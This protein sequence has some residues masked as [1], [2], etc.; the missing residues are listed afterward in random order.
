[1]VQIIQNLISNAVKF[2][3]PPVQPQVHI[4]A[5]ENPFGIRLWV[6]DN[7]LG[8]AAQHHERIFRIFERLHN[9]ESYP[10]TGVGLALVRKGIERLGG[11]VGVESEIGRGS[12]FWLEL[13]RVEEA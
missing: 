12:R 2:V 9:S 1:M 3:S 5:E 8:I 11:R 4:W 10:G 7:G 6:K 13:L